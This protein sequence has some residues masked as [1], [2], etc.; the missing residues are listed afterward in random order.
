MLLEVI[1]RGVSTPQLYRCFSFSLPRRRGARTRSRE[2]TAEKSTRS[3]GDDGAGRARPAHQG[4]VKLAPP[5]ALL[6]TINA[7][8][9]K[10]TNWWSS[11]PSTSRTNSASPGVFAGTTTAA[12]TTLPSRA[13]VRTTCSSHI[14][15]TFSVSTHNEMYS[16]TAKYTATSK[17]KGHP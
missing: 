12:W 9:R 8:V 5:A 4:V 13:P 1:H 14:L 6:R 11:R 7:T 16:T 15:S 10:T 2:R 17:Y 3:A